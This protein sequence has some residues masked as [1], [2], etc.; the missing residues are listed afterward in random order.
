MHSRAV[1][2]LLAAFALGACRGPKSDCEGSYESWTGSMA[3]HDWDSA[4]ELLTPEFKKKVG[5]P[6]RMAAYMEDSWKG[7]KS[8]EFSPFDIAETNAGVCTARGEMRYTVKIRGEL[9]KD[10]EQ[11][12]F[13]YVFRQEKDGLWYIELPGNERI[14]S[15]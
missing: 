9:P 2:M 12:Y 7:S 5:S 4:Y 3:A 6:K 13:S 14:Q 15:F 10:H 1:F 8:F 11:V